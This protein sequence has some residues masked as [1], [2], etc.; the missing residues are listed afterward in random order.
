MGLLHILEERLIDRSWQL[1]IYQHSACI[2]SKHLFKNTHLSQGRA[3]CV[4]LQESRTPSCR[5]ISS[6]NFS[7]QCRGK[8][9]VS[10]SH[11]KIVSKRRPLA[12]I[13]KMRRL[14]VKT[15]SNLPTRPQAIISRVLP[16]EWPV[17]TRV[18][19]RAE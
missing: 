4:D 1:H 18:V 15:Q 11:I 8:T 16:S 3:P 17:T 10:A 2:G 19:P 5:L 9:Q 6:N 12:N 7:T 13:Y 14:P